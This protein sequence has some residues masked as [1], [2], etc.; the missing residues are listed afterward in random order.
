MILIHFLLTDF[1][2]PRKYLHSCKSALYIFGNTYHLFAPGP[3]IMFRVTK[4]IND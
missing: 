3:S 2:F 4:V 1:I